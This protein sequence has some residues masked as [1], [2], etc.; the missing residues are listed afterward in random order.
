MIPTIPI[1]FLIFVFI[2]AAP[3]LSAFIGFSMYDIIFFILLSCFYRIL[4]FFAEFFKRS[5]FRKNGE[6][7]LFSGFRMLET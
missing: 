1:A 2:F 4:L 6:I 7:H 5:S 3:S